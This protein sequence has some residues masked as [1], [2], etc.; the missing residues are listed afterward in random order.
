MSGGVRYAQ[1]ALGEP[2][3]SYV[4]NIDRFILVSVRLHRGARRVS[5]LIRER[6]VAICWQ[7]RL[8]RPWNEASSLKHVLKETEPT[9]PPSPRSVLALTPLRRESSAS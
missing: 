4:G 2:V 1:V 6:C 8:Y 5:P 3:E 7:R 9:R